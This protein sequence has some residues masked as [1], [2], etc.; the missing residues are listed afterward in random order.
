MPDKSARALPAAF[1][2]STGYRMTWSGK[3]L[4]AGFTKL[5]DTSGNPHSLS[6]RKLHS[7][8][9]FYEQRKPV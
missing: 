3:S 9:I 2:I 6:E 7:G 5:D 1:T 4:R 8:L